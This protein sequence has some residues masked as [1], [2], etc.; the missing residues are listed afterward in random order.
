MILHAA[1][2][3]RQYNLNG[4]MIEPFEAYLRTFGGEH[5]PYFHLSKTPSRLLTM[6]QALLSMT[7]KR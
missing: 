3:T 5:V 7:G 2:V 1:G 4:S 6:R